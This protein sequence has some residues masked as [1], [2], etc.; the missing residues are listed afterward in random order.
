MTLTIFVSMKESFADILA[1][2]ERARERKV[3][4][5]IPGWEDKEIP[6]SLALEQCSSAATAQYKARFVHGKV[7]DLTGGL[8]VDSLAFSEAADAVWYNEM[9]SELYETAGR[10]FA[11][12]GTVNMFLNNY[13]VS[14][15]SGDWLE[16]LGQFGPD[17]IYLDPA[18]RNAAG[19][20][21]FRV[22]DCSPDVVRLL[23]ALLE[24]AP[25]V[26]VKLSPMA[27]IAMVTAGFGGHLEELHIVGSAGEC[28]ELL[29]RLGRGIVR[30]PRI[31]ATDLT[32]E[33]SFTPSEE[34]E[35]PARLA[36]EPSDWLYEPGPVLMKTGAFKLISKRFNVSK[37]EASTQLYFSPTAGIPLGKCRKV[38]EIVPLCKESIRE[39]RHRY[40]EADVS[41]RD[42]PI[43]SDELR[44]RLGVSPSG[45]CHIYGC[46]FRGEKVLIV[47]GK[48]I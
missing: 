8:G 38:K 34:A 30:E 35:C 17:V 2:M 3:S 23:P 10:N 13:T 39:L 7:A 4:E 12:F 27:D 6:C 24:T 44:T 43:S 1:R 47:S 36:T 5:K 31:T 19:K 33:F 37:L 29:C 18:R 25:E 28:K 41:A 26:M 40:P 42:I 14:T 46:R 22:E 9:K 32:D 45:E 20:K 15:E 48:A 11:R 21:V 16:A